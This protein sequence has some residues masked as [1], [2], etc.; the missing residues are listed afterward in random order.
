M[1]QY[2]HALSI[3]AAVSCKVEINYITGTAGSFVQK[4]IGGKI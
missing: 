3:S 1:L 2:D 4:D